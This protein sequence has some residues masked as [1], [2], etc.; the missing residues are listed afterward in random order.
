MKS[1]LDLV[2]LV[3]RGE[4]RDRWR[5]YSEELLSVRVQDVVDDMIGFGV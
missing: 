2:P 3:N 5:E 4:I 1:L